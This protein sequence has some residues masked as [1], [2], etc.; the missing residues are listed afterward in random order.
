MLT[1]EGTYQLLTTSALSLDEALP[2]L[3]EKLVQALP[4][5][6]SEAADPTPERSSWYR[7]AIIQHLSTK[8][9]AFYNEQDLSLQPIPGGV[10]AA[11]MLRH[12]GRTSTLVGA[13]A[14][15]EKA[16]AA[17]YAHVSKVL[18]SDAELAPIPE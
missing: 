13:G 11:V 12:A 1:V 5:H 17:L 7:E 18:T 3:Y 8:T 2:Q 9:H 14:T 4:S 15:C 6:L 10:R 16:L